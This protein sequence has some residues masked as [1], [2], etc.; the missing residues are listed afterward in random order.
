MPQRFHLTVM[1]LMKDHKSINTIYSSLITSGRVNLSKHNTSKKEVVD[2]L[3][4]IGN[5][6]KC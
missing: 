6:V 2:Y 4:L 1:E 3:K 5:S